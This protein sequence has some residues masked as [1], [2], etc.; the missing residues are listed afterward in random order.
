MGSRSA[1]TRVGGWVRRASGMWHRRCWSGGRRQA[2]SGGRGGASLTTP[3]PAQPQRSSSPVADLRRRPRPNRRSSPPPGCPSHPG[4][5]YAAPHRHIRTASPAQMMHAPR[6]VEAVLARGA[7]LQ[8]LLHRLDALVNHDAVVFL[9]AVAAALQVE[10]GI[11]GQVL[12]VSGAVRLGPRHLA[13]VTLHLEVVVAL[14]AAESEHLRARRR[15]PPPSSNPPST[16]PAALAVRWLKWR[17]ECL[18]HATRRCATQ[19][20]QRLLQAK[21]SAR[22]QGGAPRRRLWRVARTHL[23]VISH[24]CD[25]VRRVARAGAEPAFLQAHGA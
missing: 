20:S 12:P 21:Q 25:A 14:G 4:D 8:D 18:V 24:E 19:P 17:H 10:G 1:A 6:L 11:V 5:P 16:N 15:R 23:A 3:P 22:M 2:A 7:D 13:R 9:R